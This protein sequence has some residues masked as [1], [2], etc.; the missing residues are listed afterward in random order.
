VQFTGGYC[1]SERSAC[2]K[3]LRGGVEGAGFTYSSNRSGRKNRLSCSFQ[4]ASEHRRIEEETRLKWSELLK[5]GNVK[6]QKDVVQNIYT[7]YRGSCKI[8][9]ASGR[10]IYRYAQ[11]KEIK[12]RATSRSQTAVA[13]RDRAQSAIDEIARAVMNDFRYAHCS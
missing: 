1:T 6:T 9:D 8:T 12:T 3:A 10:I 13:A 11:E 5:R 7:S 2:L 4:R